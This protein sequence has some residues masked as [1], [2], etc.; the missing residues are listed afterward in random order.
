MARAKHSYAVRLEVEGGNRVKAELTS[1]GA[2]GER[3]MR[4]I[5]RASDRASRGLGTLSDRASALRGRMR[6][7]SGAIAGVVG[8]AAVGGLAALVKRSVDA[9]DAIAKTADA[10]GVSTDTLQELRFAADLAGVSTEQ[11]DSALVAFSKRVGEARHG[12]GTLITILKKMDPALLAN[13]QAADTVDEAFELIMRRAGEMGSTL[14][15]NALLAAAFGRT[16]GPLM[17]NLIK[18]GTD[19]IDTLRER[20]RELGI[21]IDEGLLRDAERA[22]DQLTILATVISANVNK[23]VL[24]HAD[25]IADLAEKFSESLPTLISWVENFGKWIGLIEETPEER[26]AQIEERIAEIDETLQSWFRRALEFDIFGREGPLAK[27]RR[28]LLAELEAIQRELE[29]ATNKP[30]LT[31]KPTGTSTIPA[32]PGESDPDT[33]VMTA[34]DRARRI[35]QIEK[36]LN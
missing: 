16:A 23:A 12:T 27:E 32:K 28:A 1:V 6:L 4:R 5:D 14:D 19:S 10:I 25:A 36:S 3:S 2:G 22:K 34:E 8:V 24:E 33:P 26:L 31:L 20:A 15:R 18:E 9:A 30:T 7:L 17:A 11:L 29:E 21:V 13:V 35:L